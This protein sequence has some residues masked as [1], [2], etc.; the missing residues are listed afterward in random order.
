MSTPPMFGCVV[1]GRLVQFDAQQVS[2]TQVIFN[3]PCCDQ[4]NHVA[5]FLTGSQPLPDGC[6]AAIYLCWP[7]PTPA[8]FMLGHISN[9]KPSVIFKVAKPKET[10]LQNLFAGWQPVTSNDAMAQIGIS[11]EPM[12]EVAGK[13]PVVN[14][15]AST[16]NSFVEFTQ[17][18]LT[19]VFNFCSSFAQT[20]VEM[21]MQ[22][23][24]VFVPLSA[25]QKWYETFQR[26]MTMDP[27]FWKNL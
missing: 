5:L 2:E 1:P 4:I 15:D 22:P 13:T 26:K 14:S 18:M 16:V 10:G 25:L 6:A 19:H 21:S 9:D 12:A 8:W 17:K 11:L 23:N 3:L 7:K 27:T 24:E 20:Q